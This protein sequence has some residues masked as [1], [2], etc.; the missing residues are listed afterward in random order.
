[1]Q[2]HRIACPE[3]KTNFKLHRFRSEFVNWI[4]HNWIT[5]LSN[6]GQECNTTQCTIWKTHIWLCKQTTTTTKLTVRIA[7]VGFIADCMKTTF[8]LLKR[9][10][11]SFHVNQKFNQIKLINCC[12]LKVPEN[13][14]IWIWHSPFLLF[15]KSVG[16]LFHENKIEKKK[17]LPV[18]ELA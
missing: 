6:S 1:M 5:R 8:F 3:I 18:Y 14:T 15:N 10:N 9:Q 11:F 2:E 17:K 4:D 7:S 13:G 12:W 16:K